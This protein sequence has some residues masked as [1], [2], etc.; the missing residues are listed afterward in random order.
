MQ[1]KYSSKK[2]LVFLGIAAW[3]V[4]VLSA[5]GTAGAPQDDGQN[6]DLGEAPNVDDAETPSTDDGA[7]GEG[8]A[9]QGADGEQGTPMENEAF[10]VTQPRANDIIGMSLKVEGEARVFEGNFHY[11]LEDGHNILAEGAG[12]ADKGA[13]EWGPFTL[14]IQ[15]QEAPTSPH[16]MLILYEESAKDGTPVNELLVPLTFD[17][18]IVKPVGAE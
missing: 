9:N 2:S 16:G 12:Q 18:K 11:T 8:S 4:L 15:L 17:E 7:R 13:P 5:C 6:Q 3:L 14:E 1:K 10:R